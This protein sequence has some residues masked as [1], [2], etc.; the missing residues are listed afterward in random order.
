[1]R[2]AFVATVGFDDFF[3]H[4]RKSLSGAVHKNFTK[5][6]QLAQACFQFIKLLLPLKFECFL[7]TYLFAIFKKK[8]LNKNLEK[9]YAK[10]L[11]F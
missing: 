6:N 11:N 7:K 1:M 4:E 2:D 10:A 3:F 9:K 5:K 8:C